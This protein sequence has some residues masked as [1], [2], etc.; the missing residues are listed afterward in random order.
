MDPDLKTAIEQLTAAANGASIAANEAKTAAEESRR[1]VETMTNTVMANHEQTQKEIR[2]INRNVGT[3]WKRVNGGS[4]PPGGSG[5]MQA[6]TV[7]GNGNTDAATPPLSEQMSDFDSRASSLSLE[8]QALESRVITE[9]ASVKESV[10]AGD[11]AAV[12]A[13]NEA[14]SLAAATRK[15]LGKKLDDQS[16]F[17]GVNV[18]GL[19]WFGTRDGAKAMLGIVAAVG[20]VWAAV[21]TGT[22]SSP[23]APSP[24]PPQVVYVSPGQPIPVLIATDAGH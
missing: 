17:M 15:D 13:A 23:S 4:P 19:K 1:S 22:K 5:E 14:A 20:A 12:A 7:N 2:R 18:T 9:M 10:K 3:L 6:V 24:V 8:L 21:N 11:E 16:T